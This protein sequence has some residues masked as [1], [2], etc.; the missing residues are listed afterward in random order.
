M[1][2]GVKIS[3]MTTADS[4]SP[5]AYVPIVQGGVN[6][7][8]LASLLSPDSDF[9]K[10]TFGTAFRLLTN[11]YTPFAY[12]GGAYLSDSLHAV[13]YNDTGY[14]FDADGNFL[15][16]T[17]ANTVSADGYPSVCKISALRLA[18][19]DYSDEL[20]IYE[21]TDPTCAQVGN[22]Y[23]GFTLTNAHYTGLVYLSDNNFV[24]WDGAN[25][26]LV[27]MT[28]DETDIT[29]VGA[30]LGIT[31]ATGEVYLA[32]LTS[33]TFAFYSLAETTLR[34]ITVTATGL[35]ITTAQTGITF[36]A[37]SS[38]NEY[39]LLCIN[40]DDIYQ[41]RLTG[42]TFVQVGTVYVEA[43]ETLGIIFNHVQGDS[44]ALV[45][46][47][48]LAYMKLPFQIG[49][50]PYLVGSNPVFGGCYTDAVGNYGDT[51]TT[52]LNQIYNLTCGTV[53]SYEQMQGIETVALGGLKNTSGVTRKFKWEADLYIAQTAAT[54]MDYEFGC[55]ILESDNVTYRE[56]GDIIPMTINDTARAPTI[57]AIITLGPDETVFPRVERTSGSARTIRT[58]ANISIESID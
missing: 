12:R 7:K 3:E 33:G 39:D 19:L 20:K 11:S 37:M 35:E 31:G 44:F 34:L 28:F 21:Y 32:P 52:N 5:T 47:T 4:L 15:D 53:A 42:S 45:R 41:Y 55:R 17:G 51:A 58:R 27:R 46:S 43:T 8:A 16:D 29:T 49:V 14:L 57:S 25:K 38:I 48:S 2:T 26:Q 10:P 30:A 23:T 18:I 56:H 6:Y 1:V 9:F 50:E 13:L 22:T 36:D 54:G 24:A 40:G